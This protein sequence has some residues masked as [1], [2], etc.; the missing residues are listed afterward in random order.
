MTHAGLLNLLTKTLF[1]ARVMEV[2]TLY[3]TY[4]IGI[5][6]LRAEVTRF[7]SRNN[8]CKSISVFT[9][10]LT[11]ICTDGSQRYAIDI[12]YK[13]KDDDMSV[14]RSAGFRILQI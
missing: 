6:E 3:N 4:K 11:I 9:D 7:L 5:D 14:W 8:V 10:A 13:V 2:V 12:H 1:P